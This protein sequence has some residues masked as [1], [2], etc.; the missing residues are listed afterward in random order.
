M[1]SFRCRAT[2][3][4]SGRSCS[5]WSA[6]RSAAGS[7][8]M[9]ARLGRGHRQSVSGKTE[10]GAKRSEPESPA[11]KVIGSAGHWRCRKANRS[12]PAGCMRQRFLRRSNI[13]I[14]TRAIAVCRWLSRNDAQ[15][16]KYDERDDRH[17]QPSRLKARAAKIMQ[18]LHGDRHVTIERG[19]ER[20]NKYARPTIRRWT[21]V[22]YR[23]QIAIEGKG[24]EQAR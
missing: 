17:E 14:G 2:A 8:P 1:R 21:A 15:R 6:R 19:D 24:L 5:P 9:S 3:L 4:R 10:T 23:N 11:H 18:P 12:E 20:Q 13:G 22:W 16:D 7:R